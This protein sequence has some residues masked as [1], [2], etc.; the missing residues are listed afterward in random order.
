[1]DPHESQ[2]DGAAAS[3]AQHWESFSPSGLRVLAVDDD[4]LCLKVI[5]RMLQQCN[6]EGE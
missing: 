6:Y 5:S 2:D 1:M 4:K 3:D